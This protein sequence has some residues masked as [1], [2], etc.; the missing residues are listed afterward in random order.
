LGRAAWGSVRLMWRLGLGEVNE[1]FNWP[2]ETQA[3]HLPEAR[4][5]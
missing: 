3:A 4:R 5:G 2:A 1:K